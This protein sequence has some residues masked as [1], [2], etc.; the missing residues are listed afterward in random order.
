MSFD[1]N[2]DLQNSFYRRSWFGAHCWKTWKRVRKIN[3]I[4]FKYYYFFNSMEE[5]T[6]PVILGQYLT[7]RMKL[8][9][10]AQNDSKTNYFQDPN[11]ASQETES[12]LLCKS[13]DPL[14]LWT[15]ILFLLFM[16]TPEKCDSARTALQ[17][18][19]SRKSLGCW[20]GSKL[21][22]QRSES[23]KPHLLFGII[24]T[25]MSSADWSIS[26][27]PKRQAVMN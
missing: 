23:N 21:R 22:S 10:A 4:Q 11:S 25:W 20:S 18:H 1:D 5:L 2:K 17:I 19:R 7:E 13:A 8:L 26:V 15:T 24:K 12:A 14:N 9:W 3:A 6:F 27:K 16:L